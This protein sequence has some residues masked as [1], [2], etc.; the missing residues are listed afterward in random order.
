MSGCS[1]IPSKFDN[2][3]FGYLSEL[4]VTSTLSNTCD[5]QEIT[6]MKYLS[7]VLSVYSSNTLNKNISDIY[8]E[9][10][11]LTTEL[12]QRSDPSATY[13]RLKRKNITEVADHALEVFGKRRK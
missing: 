13:C 8:V 6:Q 11:E 12:S 5:K 3:E 7:G 4:R 1:L 10:Y 2:V 9:L